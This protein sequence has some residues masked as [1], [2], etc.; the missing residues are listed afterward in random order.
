[1]GVLLFAVGPRL[2][3]VEELV[4]DA[5]FDNAGAA[6]APGGGN[7]AVDQ[8]GFDGGGGSEVGSEG[9]GVAGEGAAGFGGGQELVGGES[10]REGV[11]DGSGLAGGGAGAG[12]FEG[13]GSV[14]CYLFICGHGWS[15]IELCMGSAGREGEFFGKLLRGWGLEGGAEWGMKFDSQTANLCRGLECIERRIDAGQA[16]NRVPH[17]GLEAVSNIQAGNAWCFR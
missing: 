6:E 4:V 2:E 11:A 14:G 17:A 7:D 10:E 8:K 16:K 3:A 5:G 15:L 13:I 12:G 1:M 9:R